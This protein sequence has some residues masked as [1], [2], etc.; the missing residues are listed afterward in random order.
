MV[1]YLFL[2]LKTGSGHLAPAM[3]LSESMKAS[4][5]DS[6]NIS[7]TDGLANSPRVIKKL[8]E[9][10]YRYSINKAL[11]VFE[12]LYAIN[13]IN[14][15]SRATTWIVSSFITKGLEY[16]I[17]NQAP[18]KI[19]IF[20]FFLIEPVYR[21]LKR[22]NL[23]IPVLTIVTDP[24]SAPPIWF[25]RKE[26][27][28]IVF[29]NIV[30]EYCIKR[31]IN[32]DNIREFPFILNGKFN[33]NADDHEKKMIRKTLGFSPGSRIILLLGGGDGI[34]KGKG[35]LKSMM[36]SDPD[37][38]IAVVCG[39]NSEFRDKATKL[40]EKFRHINIKVF[41]YID[42]VHD[43]ISISDAV[44]TKCGASTCM[45]ILFLGKIP[46]IND[47]IWEQEKGNM[48]FITKGKM[49]IVERRISNVPSVV[50][51]LFSDP[52]YFNYLSRNI[53][54]AALKNGAAKVTDYLL[55]YES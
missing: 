14:F 1:N 42:F 41:G 49:G 35:L 55:G 44:I 5:G 12:L 45:E 17:I 3:A 10:G 54:N 38:E 52:A 30:R 53:Q 13:K 20:H 21:V 32:P 11:W 36:K 43:L 37:Y 39:N 28:Y 22:H 34:P 24:Y 7:L 18:D 4:C 6:M 31:G 33:R 23:K 8:I 51:N 50:K 25:L 16:Q 40:A 29:S 47:Y 48:E 9:N 2:Y 26:Q 19:I 46:I 15:V 27:K